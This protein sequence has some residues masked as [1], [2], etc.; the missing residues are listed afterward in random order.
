MFRIY[1]GGTCSVSSTSPYY[2]PSHS[3]PQ[4]SVEHQYDH[5]EFSTNLGDTERR[6]RETVGRLSQEVRTHISSQYLE[7]LRQQVS[8]GQYQPS[9]HKTASRMLLMREDG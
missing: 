2:K 3:A 1:T 4:T 8:S 5:M 6:M 7:E 9:T